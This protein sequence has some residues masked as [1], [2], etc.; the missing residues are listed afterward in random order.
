S[1][2]Y[3]RAIPREDAKDTDH[4]TLPP[5][6]HGEARFNLRRIQQSPRQ[7]VRVMF[8]GHRTAAYQH[9]TGD[10]FTRGDDPADKIRRQVVHRSDARPA[11]VAHQAY[12][13]IVRVEELDRAGDHAP[14][15]AV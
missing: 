8:D 4:A 5:D 12:D 9:L 7:I 2:K 15:Q 3:A 13:A 6:R 1:R 11:R 10:P 14:E